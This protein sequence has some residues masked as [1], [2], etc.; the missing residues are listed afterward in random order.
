MNPRA[1]WRKSSHSGMA[2]N[3]DCVEVARL[4]GA[5]GVRDSKSPAT[6]NLALPFETFADLVVRIKRDE[7]AL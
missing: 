4:S 5:V 1:S 3:S 6:G 2:D 7:L